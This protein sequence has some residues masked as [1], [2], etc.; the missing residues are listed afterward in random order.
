MRDYYR[1]E[2]EEW[3]FLENKKVK[4]YQTQAIK[5][6]K[7]N[8]EEY[9]RQWVIKELIDEYKYPIEQ[10]DVESTVRVGA[11][12]KFA[13][14]VIYNKAGKPFIYVETKAY[15][16]ID[17]SRQVKS[18]VAAEITCLFGVWTNGETNVFIL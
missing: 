8:L 1:I 5:N 14:V 13:D 7:S 17:D 10:L 18:Y 11:D 16:V 15:K 4:N 3:L 6:R 12:T 2:P 9:V